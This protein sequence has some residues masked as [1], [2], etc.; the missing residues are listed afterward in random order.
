MTPFGIAEI[1]EHITDIP[2][3]WR[4]YVGVIATFMGSALVVKNFDSPT[5]MTVSIAIT[6]VIGV[7]LSIVWQNSATQD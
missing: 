6:F 1:I 3:F 5:K 2:R 7:A 4:L